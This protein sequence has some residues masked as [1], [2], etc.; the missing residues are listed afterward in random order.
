MGFAVALVIGAALLAGALIAAF[1][2]CMFPFTAVLTA[3]T[4]WASHELILALGGGRLEGFNSLLLVY[5]LP[6]L[7]S[8]GVLAGCAMLEIKMGEN[9]KMYMAI[10][11]IARVLSFFAAAFVTHYYFQYNAMPLTW[12]D[13]A[14]SASTVI[15]ILLAAGAAVGAHFGLIAA[16]QTK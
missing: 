9:N 16:K 2:A 10:R 13:I 7:I 8:A 14:R 3:L 4:W 12:S 5:L 11:H 1:L 15:P 6:T